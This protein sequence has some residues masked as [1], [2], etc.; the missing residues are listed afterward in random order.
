MTAD[1]TTAPLAPCRIE[2][3]GGGAV[4][5]SLTASHTEIQTSPLSMIPLDFARLITSRR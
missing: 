1:F 5:K 3:A 2:A 4:E